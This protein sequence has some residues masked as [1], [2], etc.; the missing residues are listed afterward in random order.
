MQDVLY[1]IIRIEFIV[2]KFVFSW[3]R[4]ELMTYFLYAKIKI[5]FIIQTQ[6]E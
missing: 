2:M 6:F 3:L 5:G 1:V 4:F